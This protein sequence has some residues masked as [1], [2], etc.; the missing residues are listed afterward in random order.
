[1][2]SNARPAKVKTIS[3]PNSQSPSSAAPQAHANN[4]AD[5][6]STLASLPPFRHATL[7]PS[8]PHPKATQPHAAAFHR[9]TTHAA[10]AYLLR[11][12]SIWVASSHARHRVPMVLH[13]WARLFFDA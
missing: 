9:E 6:H 4:A 11:L 3:Y 1:M 8:S 5:S 10:S 7:A 2:K 12:V 13:F